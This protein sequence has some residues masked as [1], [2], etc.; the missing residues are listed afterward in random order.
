LPGKALFLRCHCGTVVWE[1]LPMKSV[2]L[3]THDASTKKNGK[4]EKKWKTIRKKI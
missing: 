3:K 4:P 2:D 1:E